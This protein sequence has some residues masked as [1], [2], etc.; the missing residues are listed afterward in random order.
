MVAL[1]LLHIVARYDICILKCGDDIHLLNLEVMEAD[2]SK[3][4]TKD[5]IP[6]SGSKDKGVAK[7]SHVP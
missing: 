6:N 5:G 2:K 3:K 1:R 7:V 4:Y